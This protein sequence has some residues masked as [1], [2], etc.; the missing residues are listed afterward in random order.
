MYNSNKCDQHSYTMH[1]VYITIT[2]LVLTDCK[3]YSDNPSLPLFI[4]HEQKFN[5]PLNQKR[6][7]P[8]INTRV[9]TPGIEVSC[10]NELKVNFYYIKKLTSIKCSCHPFTSLV[11]DVEFLVRNQK[12]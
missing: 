1:H 11:C 10:Y 7:S 12:L 2:Q 8:F 9:A 4:M 5:L 3:G 6:Q